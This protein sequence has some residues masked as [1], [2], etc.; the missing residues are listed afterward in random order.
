MSAETAA[1]LRKARAKIEQPERWTQRV[2]ARNRAGVVV[3]P[4]DGDAVCWCAAGAT[5]YSA[6]NTC[7]LGTAW[8]A[9][10]AA[11]QALGGS[12]VTTW[13]DDHTHAEVLALFDAAIAA[14]EAQS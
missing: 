8:N 11:A 13:N 1:V 2:F 9:L 12:G 4:T 6:P 7:V 10:D 3:H 14:E 5:S